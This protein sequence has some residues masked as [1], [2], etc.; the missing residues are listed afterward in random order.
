M[1]YLLLPQ[2]LISPIAV[3]GILVGLTDALCEVVLYLGAFPA[4][5]DQLESNDR[6]PEGHR[7]WTKSCH[8]PL[9]R[10]AESRQPE[11]L[12]QFEQCQGDI[13]CDEEVEDD[14]PI[15]T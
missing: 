6:D 3:L 15:D 13:A 7:P 11:H 14:L 9:G 10:S 1:R 8:Q 12:E 5:A 4:P 2:D